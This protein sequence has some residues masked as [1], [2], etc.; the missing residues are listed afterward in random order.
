[1]FIII[2]VLV[3]IILLII[4]LT[5]LVISDLVFHLKTTFRLR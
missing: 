3:F 5:Y 2:F 4:T 1:V